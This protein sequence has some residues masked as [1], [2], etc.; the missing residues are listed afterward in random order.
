MVL[1]QKIYQRLPEP[2]NSAILADPRW[3]SR[4]IRG[5]DGTSVPGSRGQKDS[6]GHLSQV[7]PSS[8][9]HYVTIMHYICASAIVCPNSVQHCSTQ[10]GRQKIYRQLLGRSLG[11]LMHVLQSSPIDY[12]RNES[13][14]LLLLITAGNADIQILCLT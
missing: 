12:V 8:L 1:L 3:D 13:L 2:V 10:Q 5:L 7:I 6:K 14:G 4:D 11:H 9:V